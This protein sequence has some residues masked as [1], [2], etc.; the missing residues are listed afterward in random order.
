MYTKVTKGEG[1]KMK[2]KIAVYI[3]D[4][5]YGER[6]VRYLAEAKPQYEVVY[7]SEMNEFHGYLEKNRPDI[8]L[9]QESVFHDLKLAEEKSHTFFLTDVLEEER[10]EEHV[11]FMY[12]PMQDIIRKL[13]QGEEQSIQT[14][15]VRPV[16]ERNRN[17]MYLLFML[18]ERLMPQGTNLILDAW[19]RKQRTL[20]ISLLPFD[21]VKD[22]KKG[23]FE[24]PKQ[25]VS[26]L[27]YHLSNGT[28][29]QEVI[30]SM[31]I[32]SKTVDYVMPVNHC[33]EVMDFRREMVEKFSNL[34]HETEYECVLILVAVV[35]EAIIE[36]AKHC[37]GVYLL[38]L[39]LNNTEYT[40]VV[41][42]QIENLLGK[43]GDCE[44]VSLCNADRK[45]L[46]EEAQQ[47]IQSIQMVGG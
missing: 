9:I 17:Q 22:S 25:G 18:N 8:L 6:F 45:S 21:Y 2:R 40:K 19:K 16:A 31:I 28:E 27:I 4:I 5:R 20:C 34:L 43:N 32:Y 10:L 42:E 3:P 35:T 23:T 36:L 15:K 39:D 1:V 41:K 44:I 29:S 12:Q 30:Q 24:K 13:F 47:R 46:V 37:Q 7:Y 33:L 38:S 11:L 14:K 26:D